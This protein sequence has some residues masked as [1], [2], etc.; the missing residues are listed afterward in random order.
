VE[1]KFRRICGTQAPLKMR[2]FHLMKQKNRPKP[3]ADKNVGDAEKTDIA[4]YQTP[5]DQFS[6]SEKQISENFFGEF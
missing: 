2:N 1:N 5:S 6:F 3:P 4:G